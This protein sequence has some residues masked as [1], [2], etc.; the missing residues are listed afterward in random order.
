MVGNSTGISVVRALA[1]AIHLRWQREP[2]LRWLLLQTGVVRLTSLCK[3][4]VVASILGPEAMGVFALVLMMLATAELLSDTGLQAAIIQ[5]PHVPD[6]LK[7]GAVWV[8]M[9]L[10][11]L[12]IACVLALCA[13]LVARFFEI[14][15]QTGLFVAAS[16][17][18]LVRGTIHPRFFL[19]QR[20]RRFDLTSPIE[21]TAA[22]ADAFVSVSLAFADLG[23]AAL[24][25]GAFAAEF[26][27]VGGSWLTARHIPMRIHTRLRLIRDYAMYGQWVWGASCITL[28]LNNFDK[29]IV[30]KV[31]GAHQLGLYQTAL[32]VSQMAVSDLY[33]MLAIYMLPTMAG[34]HRQSPLLARAYMLKVLGCVLLMAAFTASLIALG[35]QFILTHAL[36]PQWLDAELVLQVGC[37]TT[38]LG[39][40]IAILVTY[41]KATGRTRQVAM[42]TALQLVVVVPMALWLG[43]QWGA[44]GVVVA[45][46]LALLAALAFLL[47]SALRSDV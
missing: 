43:L 1:K 11:G 36:G 44:V 3:L 8:V 22:V 23:P 33:A 7:L 41:H 34:Q 40:G 29:L 47:Q 25:G 27:R 31:L 17:I 35:A 20:D 4:L 13:P 39:A 15:G 37:L 24:V 28:V 38:V 12:G 16:G 19:L 14:E 30:G 2:A 42:A 46:G 21:M 26:A 45:N 5:D 32:R 18:A 6:A 9:A 10:R